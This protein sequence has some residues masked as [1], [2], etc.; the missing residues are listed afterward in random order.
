M[1]IPT[2]LGVSFT[3]AEL[4][5][6]KA[7]A[8]TITALIRSK[9]I[10]NLSNEERGNELST[11]SDERLPFVHKSIN[12]YA[13]AFPN[14]NGLSYPLVWAAADF[15]TFDGL[16]QLMTA[17]AEA[18]EV[19]TEMHMVAGHFSFKFMTDQYY[20]AKRYRG[21]NVPGAQIVYDGLKGCFEGQGAT[22]PTPSTTPTSPPANNNPST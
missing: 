1:A 13:V 19:V 5:S 17:M 12:D 4:D 6:M 14:L 7:A 3:P 2:E 21:D 16:E 8:N 9:K 15:N 11:V 20:N 10:L 18:Q 22:N